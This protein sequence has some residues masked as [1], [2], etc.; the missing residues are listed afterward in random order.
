[1][2]HLETP[3]LRLRPF[4]DADLEPFLAYRSDPAIARYQSWDAPYPRALAEAFIERMKN[5]QSLAPGDWLQLAVE[6]KDQP[7]I[8]GDV[9]LHL[10]D[11]R[12]AEIGFTLARPFQ[13]KGYAT[14]AVVR[15]IDHL[16]GEMQLH[17][18]TATCDAAN[19]PSARLL[20]RVG[21]RREGHFLD[22]A[23]F[24]GD[25]CSEFLYAVLQREWFARR[26]LQ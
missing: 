20:E 21:M 10:L 17:R 6:R 1:M 14:E 16:L 18:V 11:S 24:K 25:W 15:L 9:A 22:H 2:L 26:P 8:V 4:A 3:R 13:G 23:W 5:V 7:G 12:Q 19:L